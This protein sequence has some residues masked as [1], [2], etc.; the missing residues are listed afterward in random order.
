MYFPTSSDMRTRCRAFTKAESRLQ[1]RQQF[2]QVLTRDMRERRRRSRGLCQ[3]LQDMLK[4]SGPTNSLK[5]KAGLKISHEVLS[6]T[7]FSVKVPE[8]V[9]LFS[10]HWREECFGCVC[11]KPH[12]GNVENS[13]RKP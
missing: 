10:K 8:A 12:A 4:K 3:D 13:N 2:R 9:K 1:H 6:L 11:P 7:R 5:L